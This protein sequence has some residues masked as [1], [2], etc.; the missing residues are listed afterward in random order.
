MIIE[1]VF[2]FFPSI[3]DVLLAHLR[4]K[5]YI[6][7]MALPEYSIYNGTRQ[8]TKEETDLAQMQQ[9]YIS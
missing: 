9:K 3:D 1:K 2:Y 4:P 5:I 8:S 6:T 7:G